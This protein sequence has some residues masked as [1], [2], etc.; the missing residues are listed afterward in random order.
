MRQLPAL[1][2]GACSRAAAAGSGKRASLLA[3]WRAHLKCLMGPAVVRISCSCCSVASNGR[4]PTAGEGRSAVSD[5]G[6]CSCSADE[7]PPL[8][9]AHQRLWK[10]VAATWRH[11]SACPGPDCGEKWALA[12]CAGFFSTFRLRACRKFSGS[13]KSPLFKGLGFLSGAAP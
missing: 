5:L 2:T 13:G 4:L 7:V 11:A 3:A 1:P 12:L 10:T 9:P 6:C 8:L